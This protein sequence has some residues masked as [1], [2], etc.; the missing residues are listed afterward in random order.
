[1]GGGPGYLLKLH[2][3]EEQFGEETQRDQIKLVAS[4]VWMA[5]QYVWDREA[6]KSGQDEDGYILGLQGFGSPACPERVHS[7][8]HLS[9]LCV[10]M[11][12]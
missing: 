1:M 6:K 2:L 5:G 8:P 11:V 7:G 12:S 10:S 4:R 9:P 3:K